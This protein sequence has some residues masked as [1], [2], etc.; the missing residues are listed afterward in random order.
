MLPFVEGRPGQP[1][2]PRNAA[3]VARGDRSFPSRGPSSAGADCLCGESWRGTSERTDGGGALLK[4]AKH[5]VTAG[6]GEEE[7]EGED[8][9][10]ER[11]GDERRE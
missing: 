9:E 4:H 7:E 8:R 5:R 1:T 11:E 10:K 3:L 6:R 2:R